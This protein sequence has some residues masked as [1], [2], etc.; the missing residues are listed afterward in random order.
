MS[1]Q[2]RK[3][4]ED[5]SKEISGNATSPSLHNLFVQDSNVVLLLGEKRDEFHSLTQ[6]LLHICK[7]S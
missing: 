1:D 7:Q 4:I 6:K 5:F 3:I 2:I